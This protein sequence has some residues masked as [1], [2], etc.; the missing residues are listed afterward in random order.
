MSL[1]V[2]EATPEEI[3]W[4]KSQLDP[5]GYYLDKFLAMNIK[6]GAIEVDSSGKAGRLRT[7]L[8]KAIK[9]KELQIR[10]F[11]REN[12]VLLIR[13]DLDAKREK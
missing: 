11:R 6:Y 9:Q 2:R 12:V 3:E 1:G 5:P 10:V 7:S 4:L 8:G 13:D